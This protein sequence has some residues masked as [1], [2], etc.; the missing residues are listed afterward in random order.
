MMLRHVRGR[1]DSVTMIPQQ[2]ADNVLLSAA[3]LTASC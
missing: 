3:M 1:G 2:L